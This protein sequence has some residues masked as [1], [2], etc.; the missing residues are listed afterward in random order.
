MPLSF[1]NSEKYHWKILCYHPSEVF[2]VSVLLAH[3]TI[4]DTN[5]D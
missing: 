5:D 4:K 2:G 1:S 3:F